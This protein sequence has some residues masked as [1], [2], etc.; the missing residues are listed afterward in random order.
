[1]GQNFKALSAYI[2]NF[3]ACNILLYINYGVELLNF[4]EKIGTMAGKNRKDKIIDHKVDQF[5]DLFAVF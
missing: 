2:G 5:Y 4:Q 3:N 1:M